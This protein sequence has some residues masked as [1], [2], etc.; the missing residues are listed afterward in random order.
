MAVGFS[1][2]ATAP[3]QLAV[4]RTVIQT[5]ANTAGFFYKC[6]SVIFCNTSAA[7]VTVSLYKDTGAVADNLAI[8]KTSPIEAGG[9]MTFDTVIT[10]GPN[11]SLTAL[12]SVATSVTAEANGFG[13]LA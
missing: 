13:K 12:C 2:P 3:V 11:Q 4:T 7:A 8:L 1:V 10:L 9:T 6:E 5:V